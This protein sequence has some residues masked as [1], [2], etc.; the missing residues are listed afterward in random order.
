MHK[1]K[2][3]AV[4]KPVN[5]L[6]VFVYD[7]RPNREFER[8]IN[9]IGAAGETVSFT[10]PFKAPPLIICHDKLKALPS[11]ITPGKV[12]FSGAGTGIFEIVGE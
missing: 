10:P 9:G 5:V 4:K 1:I 11:D 2:V 8:H 6:G 7:S 12:T 3:E